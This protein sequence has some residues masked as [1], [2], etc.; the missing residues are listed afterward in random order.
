MRRTKLT[1]ALVG[2]I[3]GTA[4]AG[5]TVGAQ[6]SLP[7]NALK[8]WAATN[9]GGE[10]AQVVTQEQAVATA[11]N[12]DVVVA[13]VKTFSPHLAAMRAENP[14]LKVVAY[15]NGAYVQKNQ[16]GLYPETWYARDADGN[17]VT[18]NSFGNYLMD[19]SNPAWATDRAERCKAHMAESGYD[20]CYLDMLGAA[21]VTPGYVSA[22]P[23]NPATGTAWTVPDWIGATANV[24]TAVKSAN[25]GAMIVGNGLS[26]GKDYFTGA[27]GPTSRL[28]DGVDGANAQGWFRSE[29]A[30]ITQFRNLTSWKYDVDMLVEA[31][32]RGKS[33]M[34]M[35][36]IGKD[37]TA[38][39]EQ[40]ARVR[41]Y[42]LASF[43]LG[44]DGNQYFFFG[45]AVDGVAAYD[46][47]DLHVNV[48]TPTRAYDKLSTGAYLRTFSHG[49]AVAN[50]TKSTVT[51]TLGGTYRDLD[52]RSTSRVT[53][54]PRTGMVFTAP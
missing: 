23:I 44:T 43:L 34:T 22:L 24:G 27:S 12:Y 39:P 35:T 19:V 32:G 29:N 3:V 7:V 50:P 38:T 45:D 48:G 21:S 36:K 17:Q 53:L 54:G 16:G 51:V 10:A 20:G 25:P 33:V 1:A 15:L 41:R 2:L 52:G 37:V 9:G 42:A 26:N 13:L 46:H 8:R 47:P 18:S 14:D 4:A 5:G 30:P 49:V 31:G 28:L 11:R 40:V 6:S